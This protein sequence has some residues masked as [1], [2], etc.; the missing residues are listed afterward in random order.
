VAA[1]LI[2]RSFQARSICR[3]SAGYTI[4]Y[5]NGAFSLFIG[6]NFILAEHPGRSRL[7][8]LQLALDRL[9]GDSW[10]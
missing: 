2:G 7:Q 9:L 3:I 10:S 5:R 8:V 4:Q 1:T 6:S